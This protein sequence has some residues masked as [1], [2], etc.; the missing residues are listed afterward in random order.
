LRPE[1]ICWSKGGR[2][3]CFVHQNPAA[4]GSAY[5]GGGVEGLIKKKTRITVTFPRPVKDL[6]DERTGKNHGT[7]KSATFDFN[8][9]EAVF[10]SF[11]GA[12]PE[13]K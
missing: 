1:V 9:V 13:R 5:G 3:L 7:T 11:A 8:P 2:T 6:I 12:P 4:A 10:F